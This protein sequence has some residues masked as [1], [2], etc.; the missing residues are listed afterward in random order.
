MAELAGVEFPVEKLIEY[1]V[2]QMVEHRRKYQAKSNPSLLLWARLVK[3]EAKPA[4]GPS[5]RA[6]AE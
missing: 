6:G 5:P 3:S 2:E 4:V 1:S